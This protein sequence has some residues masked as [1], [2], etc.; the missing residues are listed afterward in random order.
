MKNSV[1]GTTLLR[2]MFLRAGK[3][4]NVTLYEWIILL[5]IGV[6]TILVIYSAAMRTRVAL[7]RKKLAESFHRRAEMTRF[8]D[9][10][11]KN[12]TAAGN[13]EN[14]MNVTARYVS[15]LVDAQS[16]CIYMEE[17]GVLKVAGVFGSFPLLSASGRAQQEKMIAKPK[18]LMEL[19]K[20]EQFKMGEGLIGEIALHREDVFVQSSATDPRI[21]E[22]GT[23]TIPIRSMLA[24]PL[25][26]DGKVSGV[27][28]AVNNKNAAQP[29]SQ[30]QFRRFKFIASQVVLA[31]N[32]IQVYS[33]LSEQQR[34]S[35]ELNFA[36]NLQLSL[37]PKDIPVW[38]KFQIRAFTR[39]SKEVSGD[40]YD[41]VQIDKNRLLVVIGDACGKGIPACM[42]MAMTR[43]FIRA[44]IGRFT[45][46]KA[47]LQELNTNLY[48]DTSEG[49]Y[50]TLACCLI[51]KEES[52]I[53]CARAGHT[54]LYMFLRQHIREVKPDGAGLGLLPSEIADF[55]TVCTGIGPNTTIL[56]FTDG[57]NE[58]T[59]KNDE[60]YGLKRLTD[61]YAESC[62]DNKTTD[63][64]IEAIMN[65]VDK[66]SLTPGKDQD[67]DQTMVVIR[68]I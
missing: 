22:L 11:S 36:K 35:Q 43:A 6:C 7:L 20:H 31:Q 46:L 38:G 65:D 48:R 21:A 49:R 26:N 44:S 25:I 4:L 64:V 33:T 3:R 59:D 24:V 13:V 57:L 10:F 16:V 27:M 39:A 19:L 37:I 62:K 32:M 67:D 30:E 8:L 56:M 55:D 23:L 9:I 54:P 50:I 28:C 34:I 12:I 18:Y 47:L 68:H 40:F 60:Y 52:T 58:A 14:W 45:T 51:D 1:C 5:L 42:I 2:E 29:F 41:F 66:F 15:E 61:V 17:D 53:E 63:E